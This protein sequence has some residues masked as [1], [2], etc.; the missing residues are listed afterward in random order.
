MYRNN[1][2]NQLNFNSCLLQFFFN[3][4]LL[5]ISISDKN[6]EF[7]Q[8]RWHESNCNSYYPLALLLRLYDYSKG[9][10]SH[11]YAIKSPRIGFSSFIRARL[12]VEKRCNT[13]KLV[14]QTRKRETLYERRG[15]VHQVVF[16][17]CWPG[18]GGGGGRGTDR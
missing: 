7:R 10:I 12:R 3:R 8:S 15:Y 6:W 4:N 16:V 14:I 17:I 11:R 1:F 2:W 13:L 9:R 18:G 5:R